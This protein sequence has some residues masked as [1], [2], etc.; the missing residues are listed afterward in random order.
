MRMKS[1]SPQ[2]L[3]SAVKLNF[4]LYKL[5]PQSVDVDEIKDY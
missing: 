3:K 2:S 1:R 4:K 5:Y